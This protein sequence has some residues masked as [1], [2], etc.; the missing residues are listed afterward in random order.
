MSPTNRGVPR[1]ATRVRD[2]DGATVQLQCM[3]CDTAGGA[4]RGSL[5]SLAGVR[6]RRGGYSARP[7][8]GRDIAGTVQPLFGGSLR[9][10][11]LDTTPYGALFRC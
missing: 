2:L 10:V 1:V 4:L 11:S 7:Q 5:E 3:Q 8:I 6:S 9:S